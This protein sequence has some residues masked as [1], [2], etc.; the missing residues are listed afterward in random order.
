MGN[1]DD[2]LYK[3]GF[4]FTDTKEPIIHDPLSKKALARFHCLP[5]FIWNLYYDDCVSVGISKNGMNAVAIIGLVFNPFDGLDDPNE[6]GKKLLD[7]RSLSERAFIE[8]LS[9]LSGRFVVILK[10]EDSLEFFTDTCST[11]SV[12]YDTATSNVIFSSHATLI[13]EL[14]HYEISD[15]AYYLFNN[16]LY[17]K[18]NMKKL[19]GLTSLYDNIRPLT[20]NTKIN[21]I[22]KTITRIFPYEENSICTDYEKLEE[23]IVELMITQ[24]K[25]LSQKENIMLSLSAGMDSRLSLATCRNILDDI[26]IFTYLTKNSM[27]IEDVNTA[28]EICKYFNL[29]HTVYKRNDQEYSDGM[30]EFEQIWLKNLG[31]P[32]G[33][34]WLNK[35][36]ADNFP[37]GKI[38]LRSNIAGVATANLSSK[39][40]RYE[41]SPKT[42]AYLYTKTPMQNDERVI[43]SFKKWIE[44]TT[45]KSDH[46]YN[47]DFYDLFYWEFALCQWHSSLLLESDM[48]HDTFILFNNRKMLSKMLSLPYEDRLNKKLFF[49]II[50][51]LWPELLDFPVNKVMY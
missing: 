5:F 35:I 3:R 10:F 19:P 41:L 44:L 16:P 21:A 43:Q 18:D 31:I 50:R 11:R 13:S 32:R 37:T 48:S 28:S 14:M 30:Y 34:A 38:H 26:E 8:Y 25:M 23:E 51:K 49:G 9:E 36:Y 46:F 33:I 17:K 27:H 47:Y 40:K 29:T 45:F 20:P 24:M 6:I 39:F 1:Y 4:L 2:L 12:F 15:D 22:N 42:L 7:S